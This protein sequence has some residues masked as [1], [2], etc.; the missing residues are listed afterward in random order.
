MLFR[1]VLFMLIVHVSRGREQTRP[2]IPNVELRLGYGVWFKKLYR[3]RNANSAWKHVFVVPKFRIP[4]LDWNNTVSV[5]ANGST[6]TLRTVNAACQE[7]NRILG[8]HNAERMK[9]LNRIDSL[10]REIDGMLPTQFDD[11]DRNARAPFEFVGT[12]ASWLFGIG[13][14]SQ[15]AAMMDKVKI[16]SSTVKHNA[17]KS[18]R[19]EKRALSVLNVTNER[20]NI[21]RDNQK[22]VRNDLDRVIENMQTWQKEFKR[23]RSA[24]LTL[25]YFP[26]HIGQL[27]KVLST[28]LLV[29]LELEEAGQQ[30]LSGIQALSEGF[31]PLSLISPKVLT[32]TLQHTSERLTALYPTY[33]LRFPQVYHYYRD[34]SVLTINTEDNLYIQLTIPIDSFKPDLTVYKVYSAPVP[35]HNN[36]TGA[37]QILDLPQY[38]AVEQSRTWYRELSYTDIA[39]CTGTA[40]KDCL[41]TFALRHRNTPT[42]ASSLFFHGHNRAKK[43]CRTV[44]LPYHVFSDEI[45]DL[46]HGR[47]LIS[48]TRRHMS[49][50]CP[51]SVSRPLPVSALCLIHIQCGCSVQ[52]DTVYLPASLQSCGNTNATSRV[53]HPVNVL[54]LAELS[55]VGL[56]NPY[57]GQM[58]TEEALQL[59]VSKIPFYRG[60]FI[61]DDD[62]SQKLAVELKTLRK[63]LETDKGEYFLSH[64]DYLESKL[65][66][67]PNCLNAMTNIVLIVVDS[68]VSICGLIL[69]IRL[70]YRY[71]SLL[72]MVSII[73]IPSAVDS[74]SVFAGGKGSIT[75]NVD[76]FLYYWETYVLSVLIIVV[77][78]QTAYLFSKLLKF[79]A[80]NSV[81]F[82]PF[83]AI[84]CSVFDRNVSD[85]CL[86]LES[87]TDSLLLP[88]KSLCVPPHQI[89]LAAEVNIRSLR[90]ESNCLSVR[91]CLDWGPTAL[92][93]RTVRSSL[94]LPFT[95]PV[96]RVLVKRTMKLIH[97]PHICSLC[98]VRSNV[99]YPLEISQGER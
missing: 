42:C 7:Y 12:A 16:L 38:F 88:V 84:L 95:V 99:V 54:A 9:V 80:K 46:G 76:P 68:M 4:D 6:N 43:Q 58:S 8:H 30:Y 56:Q 87:E 75:P 22:H 29:L 48:N 73:A 97:S 44:L 33:G 98:I 20:L 61:K 26:I 40:H 45:Y 89:H 27:I 91:L 71:R 70:Y 47:A 74:A 31:L 49:F 2:Y 14:E 24:I 21:F 81:L 92:T 53:F 19:F 34:Q 77:T 82:S 64:S 67:L 86:V 23:T 90:I 10:A 51:S 41:Q 69:S 60:S 3:I 5:C 57:P 11:S 63:Q 28:D 55:R 1:I 36:G 52:A 37:T 50:V 15:I 62:A 94:H 18:R 25:S 65:S 39:A 59:N 96:P 78:V 13:T 72:N 35:I 85:L 83:S 66:K 32:A 17:E 93:V 79:M